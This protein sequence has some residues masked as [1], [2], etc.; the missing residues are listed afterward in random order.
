MKKNPPLRK[1]LV[2]KLDK[3]WSGIIH[4]K[5]KN[6]CA[7]CGATGITHAHHCIVNKGRGG[8][9]VRW[10]ISNGI[11]LCPICHLFKIHHGQ[12]DKPWLDRYLALLNE[13]TP[14]KEQENIC[15]I[16][17]QVNKFS[18]YELQ[19]MVEEMEERLKQEMK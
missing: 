3:L 8:F 19:T 5:F 16:A 4:A 2:A 1:K 18:T 10:M 11:L 6:K 14:V 12:A 7:M 17:H 15:E 13:I 9:G